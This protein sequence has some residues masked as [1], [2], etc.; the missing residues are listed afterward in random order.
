MAIIFH[1][2]HII[3]FKDLQK[4][5]HNLQEIL[6]ESYV[7]KKQYEKEIEDL[8]EEIKSLKYDIANLK[9]R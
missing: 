3:E 6:K 8:K 1:G 4:T 5:V 9:M 7:R 2:Y